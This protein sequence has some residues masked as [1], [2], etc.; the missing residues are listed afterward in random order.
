M[1]RHRKTGLLSVLRGNHAISLYR[2][3]GFKP[4]GSDKTKLHM[5]WDAISPE[6]SKDV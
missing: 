2:R 3:L 5:R 4:N 1:P 6:S